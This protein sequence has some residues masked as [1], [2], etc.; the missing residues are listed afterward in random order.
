MNEANDG[1]KN[2]L[3]DIFKSGWELSDYPVV[4]DINTVIIES[5]EMRKDSRFNSEQQMADNINSK[6]VDI[7]ANI[8]MTQSK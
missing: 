8:E 2:Q 5:K 6:S 7:E 3:G 1:Q 4:S